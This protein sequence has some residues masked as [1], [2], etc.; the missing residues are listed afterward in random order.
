M[1][2]GL[3]GVHCMS[4]QAVTMTESTPV[5]VLPVWATKS[6]GEDAAKKKAAKGGKGKVG[7]EWL[8]RHYNPQTDGSPFPPSSAVV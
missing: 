7:G 6:T 1:P 5:E 3:I 2:V 4:W 8:M